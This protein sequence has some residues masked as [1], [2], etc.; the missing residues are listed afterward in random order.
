M[1]VY[2]VLTGLAKSQQLTRYVNPFIGTIF[3]GSVYPGATLPFGMVQMSP[4]NGLTE[5]DRGEG[6][7]SG[8]SYTK[9]IIKGFSH[10]HLSGAGRPALGDISV[11]PMVGKEPSAEDIRSDISHQEESASAGY[12]SVMLKSFGIKAEVESQRSRNVG[13]T[14]FERT[15]VVRMEAPSHPSR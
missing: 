4:D 15:G 8:Y 3:E 6:L 2:L 14:G 1:L 9:N 5:K 7:S 12:Y 10:T 11:L 13:N